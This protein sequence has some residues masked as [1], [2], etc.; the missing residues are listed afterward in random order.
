[1]AHRYFD[2]V[3]SEALED[4]HYIH[5]QRDNRNLEEGIVS[6]YI[7]GQG[8]HT[9]NSVQTKNEILNKAKELKKLEIY[10]TNKIPNNAYEL[11]Y[12][13]TNSGTQWQLSGMEDRKNLAKRSAML[14]EPKK[15]TFN[16]FISK[17]RK[18]YMKKRKL[19][20]DAYGHD[21]KQLNIDATNDSY[22]E[23]VWNSST[24]H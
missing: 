1:M 23:P 22:N 12:N 18:D 13:I 8:K 24:Q 10:L 16:R 2:I 17:Q 11:W 21:Y 7:F 19:F 6:D 14:N 5:G 15:V 20:R 3:L 4:N 9:P